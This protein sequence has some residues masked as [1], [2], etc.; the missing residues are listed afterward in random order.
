MIDLIDDAAPPRPDRVSLSRLALTDF[1]NYRALTL[2]LDGRSVVLVGANGAGK[3][4]LLEAVSMLAPGRGLRR[5]THADIARAEGRGTWAVSA[6]IETAWG[7]TDIGTGLSDPDP[8]GDPQTRVVRVDGVAQRSTVALGEHLAILWLTPD[9]DGL[10]RGPAGD[11]RRFLDRLA[12]A[13]DPAHGGRVA[14]LEKLLRTR[15][16]LLES[17]APDGAWLDAVERELAEVAVAVARGRAELV[18]QLSASIAAHHDAASP[19]PDA[20]LNLD[21]TLEAALA[22][23]SAVAVEDGYMR[24]LRTE[25]ARDA[26]AGRTLVGAHASDLEVRHGPKDTPAERCSTGEQKALL[27]G[28][29][30]AHARLVAE[31][32]GGTPILLLDEI[33]A[34]LD[35]IR[36]AGLVEALE[37]L[38]AQAFLTGTD[39]AMFAALDGRAQIFEVAH[40]GLVER[41]E[42]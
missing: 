31:A 15:N 38:G 20:R 22:R 8:D 19:F 6:R 39:A 26:A 27:V 23:E 35:A 12:V 17:P 13:L 4:N 7:S 40:G 28:L 1:R 21:G 14:A 18:D 24:T 16:R 5:A 11:R 34:H 42:T 30:L 3:T 10:F 25:R 2:D 32:R 37:R 36:R 29:V 33:A 9:L 41:R